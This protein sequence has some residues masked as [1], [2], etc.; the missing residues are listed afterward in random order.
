MKKSDFSQHFKEM[1]FIITQLN[2]PKIEFYLCERIHENANICY[3]E[4]WNN[5]KGPIAVKLYFSLI[6]ATTM[7]LCVCVCVFL[8]IKEMANILEKLLD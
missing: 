3:F 2:Y 8:C 1:H 6:L 5:W 7:S 4:V